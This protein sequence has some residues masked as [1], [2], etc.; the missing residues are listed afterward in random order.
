MPVDADLIRNSFE[1]LTQH[2][3][4]LC[5]KVYALLF[6]ADPELEDLFTA[7]HSA[8]SSQMVRESLVYAFDYVDGATWVPI[9]MS[10]LGSK[11]VEYEVVEAMYEQFIDAMLTAMSELSGDQWSPELE[12]SWRE[13]L[14]YLA[15]LMVAELPGKSAD[16][17]VPPETIESQEAS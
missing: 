14:R 12:N 5:H 3:V 7:R 15:E 8:A 1:Y 10:S 11:H 2:E 6:D 4:E 16:S 17:I 13:L 9:N